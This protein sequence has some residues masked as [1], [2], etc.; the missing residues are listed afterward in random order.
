M[1]MKKPSKM[2]VAI[3]RACVESIAY[4]CDLKRL[5]WRDKHLRVLREI[6]RKKLGMAATITEQSEK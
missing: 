4:E 6:H 2:Q 3:G 5:R 1:T